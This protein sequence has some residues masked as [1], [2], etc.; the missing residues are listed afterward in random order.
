KFMRG[1]EGISFTR[2]FL[3]KMLSL[4]TTEANRIL[5]EGRGGKFR[6][7][8]KSDYAANSKQ[9]LDLEVETLTAD[10][11]VAYGVKNLSGGEKFLIS[12]ALSLGLSAV[13]RSRS[14]GIDMEAMFID[15]GFGSLDPA[16]LREAVAILC[17]LAAGRTT[18]GIISHVEE[19][20]NVIPCGI[21]VRK[22]PDGTS[23][24]TI[25]S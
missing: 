18:I 22:N 23:S 3:G 2:Y 1:D 25:G 14:G 21:S 11:K 12:L 4:V 7:R 5:G 15:E 6:L 13:A 16:S 17:G 10:F 8:V 19:L 20:Q 9:G 24:V